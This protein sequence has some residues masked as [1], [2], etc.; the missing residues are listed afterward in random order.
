[1]IDFPLASLMEPHFQAFSH[2]SKPQ[3]AQDRLED[4]DL[5]HHPTTSDM[6]AIPS[7]KSSYSVKGRMTGSE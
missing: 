7:I 1:V 6:L 5:G 4:F 2:S 3:A